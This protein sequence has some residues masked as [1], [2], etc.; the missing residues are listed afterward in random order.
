MGR[1]TSRGWVTSPGSESIEE[2][3]RQNFTKRVINAGMSEVPLPQD[4]RSLFKCHF[5]EAL[6]DYLH[7]TALLTSRA[8][9]PD[10]MLLYTDFFPVFCLSPHGTGGSL[11]WN[12]VPPQRD[13]FSC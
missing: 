5:R 8:L 4:F 1:L 6:P 2:R 7:K 10:L 12:L 11:Y 13:L 9:Q 3:R